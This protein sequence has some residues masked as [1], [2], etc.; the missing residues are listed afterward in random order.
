M[1]LLLHDKTKKQIDS[2]IRSPSNGIILTGVMGA[3][4]SHLARTI[5]TNLIGNKSPH[6]YEIYGLDSGIDDVRKIQKKLTL[7]VPGDKQVRRIVI[8][9]D[10][11]SLGHEAQNALLKTLEE[12]PLDTVLILTI[13]DTK[14]VLP[15]I[16]SRVP[17]L[18]VRP[19][20]RT[21]ALAFSS[22]PKA[23]SSFYLSGGSAG[24]F[25]SLLADSKDHPLAKAV[26]KSKELLSLE[27][28]QRLS[29][30]DVLLKDKELDTKIFLDGMLRLINASYALAISSHKDNKLIKQQQ[31]RLKSILEANEDIHSG[32][33]Q[34]LVLSR[35]F[36]AL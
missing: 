6:L 15:T 29:A 25:V 3:G 19:V 10:F 13:S 12:P 23:E 4:K 11:D 5:A 27:K 30:I 17:Q 31:V 28:Y 26:S 20:T 18:Y 32:V 33:H 21:H 22:S 14:S 34:K 7:Q 9:N 8:F 2:F 16:F 24:L 36:L 1:S 35:L